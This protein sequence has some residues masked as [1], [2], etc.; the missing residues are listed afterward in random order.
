MPSSNHEYN[1]GYVNG[2]TEARAQIIKIRSF[3]HTAV[4]DVLNDLDAILAEIMEKWSV[5]L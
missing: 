4:Y 2:L 5:K 3:G 1:R